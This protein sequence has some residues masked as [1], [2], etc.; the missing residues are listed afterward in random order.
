MKYSKRWQYDNILV[1]KKIWIQPS[2]LSLKFLLKNLANNNIVISERLFMILYF[3]LKMKQLQIIDKGICVWIKIREPILMQEMWT[4]WGLLVKGGFGNGPLIVF[5]C[6]TLE[7][8][9]KRMLYEGKN[10]TSDVY[11]L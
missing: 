7:E 4:S 9:K 3:I 10:I 1:F 11:R 2:W 8:W 6:K 5:V